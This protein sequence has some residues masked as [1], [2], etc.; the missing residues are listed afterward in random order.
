MA[1]AMVKELV[2]QT[3]TVKAKREFD[4]CFNN[5]VGGTESIKTGTF[6][7]RVTKQWHDYETGWRFVGVLLDKKD[8][9]RFKKVGTTGYAPKGKAYH[10]ELV[11][12]SDREIE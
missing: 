1:I 12:F 6:R 5:D 4:V 2:G 10:P 9:D 11:Y 3:I 7:V 8:L